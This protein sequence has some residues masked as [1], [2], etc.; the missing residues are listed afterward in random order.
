MRATISRAASRGRFSVAGSASGTASGVQRRVHVAG[1][2]GDDARRRAAQLLVPDPAQVRQ[3]RL[4]RAVRAPAG[5]GRDRGVARD[6]DHQRARAGA[7]RRAPTPRAAPSSA[8]VRRNG[9]T[10]VGRERRLE[11]LAVGVGEQ[12]ERHRAE[13]RG[14]VDEDVEAAERGADL[15]RDAVRCLPCARRR[16]RCRG[17]RRSARATRATRVAVAGDEGDLRRRARAGLDQRQAE[18][19]G[20]AGDGDAQAR[21]RR[22]RCSS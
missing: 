4:A 8:L 20:A 13:A 22:S 1:V 2:D 7:R 9:P 11:V 21:A 19:G 6:V 17:C 12:R 15:Q 16:R 10:Q 3:R 18:A 5:I 14:V